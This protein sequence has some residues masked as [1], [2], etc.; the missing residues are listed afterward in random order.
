M[1]TF[2]WR[3]PPFKVNPTTTLQSR[4]VLLKKKS[5]KEKKKKKEIRFSSVSLWHWKQISTTPTLNTLFCPGMTNLLPLPSTVLPLIN[6][7]TT[8]LP[9]SKRGF[10]NSIAKVWI[11]PSTST[12]SETSPEIY[13]SRL[14]KRRYPTVVGII[15]KREYIVESWSVEFRQIGVIN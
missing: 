7:L 10:G 5:L 11:V 9:L 14:P 13:T 15:I 6:Q 2:S 8:T 4:K 3:Q 1:H 12:S